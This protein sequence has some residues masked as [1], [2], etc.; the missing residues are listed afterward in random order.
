MTGS[1]ENLSPEDIKGRIRY[2]VAETI[3]SGYTVV[4]SGAQTGVVRNI[5]RVDAHAEIFTGTPVLY[6]TRINASGTEKVFKSYRFQ[7]GVSGVGTFPSLEWAKEDYE[8][9]ASLHALERLQVRCSISGA[10]SVNVEFWDESGQL[11]GLGQ[12]EDLRDV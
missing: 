7:G 10:V 4:V 3:A 8:P 1:W 11:D 5:A 2:S 6:I 12:V 9:V